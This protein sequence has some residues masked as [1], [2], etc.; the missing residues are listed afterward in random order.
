MA[1]PERLY[2]LHINLFF[3]LQEP[4]TSVIHVFRLLRQHQL[5]V[6]GEKCECEGP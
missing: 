6:K 4:C 1:W 5:Y 2:R 3:L